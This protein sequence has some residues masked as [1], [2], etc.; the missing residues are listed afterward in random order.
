MTELK[1]LSN[2]ARSL[3]GIFKELRRRNEITK[4]TNE[5]IASGFIYLGDTEDEVLKH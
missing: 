2:I 4:R 3:D 1:Y 5:I